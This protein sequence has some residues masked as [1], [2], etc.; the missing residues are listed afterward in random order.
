MKHNSIESVSSGLSTGECG[1]WASFNSIDEGIEAFYLYIK[2]GYLERSNP[3][4]T[5]EEITCATGSGF[6]THCYCGTTAEEHDEWARY[7]VQFR[8]EISSQY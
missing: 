1:T 8:E 7:V 2:R 3:Q 5:P 6:T 4:R